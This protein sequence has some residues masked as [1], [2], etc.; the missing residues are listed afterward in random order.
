MKI[1]FFGDSLTDAF[2][3]RESTDTNDRFGCG[4]IAQIAGRLLAE[5]PIGYDIINRGIGGNR[6]VDLYARI[7]AD[8]WNH[9]PDVLNILVGVNDIWHEVVCQNGVDVARFEHIYRLII[10]ETKERLPDIKIILCEPFILHG[11]ATNE[12][13]EQ[14]SKVKE[15]AAVVEKLATEYGLPFLPLREKFEKAQEKFG[16][17]VY[18]VDG[19]HPT[20]AGAALIA[21]EWLKL[22]QEEI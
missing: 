22:F 14:L 6:I 18:V 21:E 1:L 12:D 7:K 9:K 16:E 19:V 4:F 20:I 3:N 17:G 10:Q 2:R 13:Y 11:F 5:N 8:V 15:Y